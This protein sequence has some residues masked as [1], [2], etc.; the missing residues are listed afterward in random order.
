MTLPFGKNKS[1]GT[2]GLD[3][4]G[5]YLAAV[6][7][8]GGGVARAVS[9]ELAPGLITDGEV[10]DVEGLGEALG[11]FFRKYELP[12][13]VHLGV[14]NQ[15]VAVRHLELPVIEDAKERDAAVRFQAAEAVAMPL[16][17][18][19]LD[20]QV[21]GQ[22]ISAE[23]AARMQIVVV[24]ARD[25]MITR[26]V[27]AA[28]LAG[29]KP[30]GIDLNAFALVRTLAAPSRDDEPEIASDALA[31]VY[32]HLAGVTNL[33]VAHGT[34]CLFT[35]PLSTVWDDD[36]EN[37]AAAL[38]EEIRLSIDYYMAQPEAK[39]AG[40]VVLSGPG[41]TRPGLVDELGELIGLPVSGADPLGTL[42][43]SLPAEEDPYRHTIAAGLALG[44]MS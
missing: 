13:G 15:Q 39:P 29:L 33:A 44:D 1:L 31:R 5:A 23:G 4:D 22:T 26:F 2:V 38:A 12:R 16:E 3:I 32:C 36:A 10:A 34:S 43:A 14:A 7:T 28:R 41:S 20:Y 30:E 6:Q 17:E 9:S 40:D 25:S 8:S 37:T 27:D 42:I 24:A 19:V 21:V 35:R 11:L 18:V